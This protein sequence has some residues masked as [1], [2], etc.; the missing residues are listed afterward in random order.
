MN[1]EDQT[2]NNTSP[3]PKASIPNREQPFERLIKLRQHKERLVTDGIQGYELLEA[4][5]T[6]T[7]DHKISTLR[8]IRCHRCWHAHRY[9]L[10]SQ[11]KVLDQLELPRNDRIFNI[12]FCLLMHHKEYLSAG[13]SAKL[14]LQLLPNHTEL[15]LFGKVGEVDRLFQE[16]VAD[17]QDRESTM[18]LWPSSTAISVGEFL[19]RT[20]EKKRSATSEPTLRVIVLDGTYTQA[21]NMYSS[22]RKRWGDLP[23]AVALN[24][25]SASVFHRAQ[26]NYGEAHQ[27]QKQIA[28]DKEH[29]QRVS[30]AEACAY[31]LSEL[32]AP[33]T[34]HEQIVQAVVA[35]NEALAFAQQLGVGR[36]I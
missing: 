17:R 10:C 35:N 24:P 28:S 3:T 5:A 36:D 25:T 16:A 31:L 13:N 19:D 32:G 2:N 34:V 26:K 8:R 20:D 15:Y 18:I 27:Q 12:K 11:L 1:D 22:L 7:I 9:C 33:L 4:M 29:V 14:L 6:L 30:T 23:A 21:R